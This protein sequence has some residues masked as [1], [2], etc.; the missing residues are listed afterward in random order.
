MSDLTSN[1]TSTESL[2]RQVEEVTVTQ[3]IDG[4][5]VDFIAE[6]T[7][8]PEG[9]IDGD[10]KVSI[11]LRKSHAS[12]DAGFDEDCV[13]AL[14]TVVKRAFEKGELNLKD[15]WNRNGGQQGNLFGQSAK[16]KSKSD[17][18]EAMN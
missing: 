9:R 10:Y 13:N 17:V 7:T 15:Y 2:I 1:L 16:G 3:N 4:T 12:T 18:A 5:D 14:V 11:K 6:L 8:I